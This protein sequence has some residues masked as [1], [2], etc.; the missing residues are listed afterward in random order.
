MDLKNRLQDD[1]KTAMRGGDKDR[2]LTLRMLSAAIKQREIDERIVLDDAQVLAVVEKLIK[3]RREAAIQY[4]AGNRP[5]LAAK[6]LGEAALLQGYL[7][8]RCPKLSSTR[9]SRRRSPI[10][11]GPA[12]GH[13]PDH[14]CAQAEDSGPGRHGRSQQ[15]PQEPPGRLTL[16]FM[17]RLD[18]RGKTGMSGS[19]PQEFIDEVL[20]RSDLV[21]LVERRI[22]SERPAGIS[23]L[24]AR[25]TTKDP[26]FTV[27][28]DKQFYHCF[29]CGA[30]GNA[31]GFLMAFDRLE[32]RDAVADLAAEAG[33]ALPAGGDAPPARH[34]QLRSALEAV[35]RYFRQ[36]LRG[37]HDAIDYLKSRGLS[38]STAATFGVGYAPARWDGVL[39]QF[40]ATRNNAPCCWS[41][42]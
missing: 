27:S 14:G 21:G 17:L 7:P 28:P 10:T 26:S 36:Q 1:I 29:G 2:L 32:F 30:H 18:G 13:G 25:S 42:G 4:E 31:I 19:I 12:S 15:A 39:T 24:A 22:P 6:E 9:S 20:A 33:L 3:Q 8:S 41:A 35:A 38:G 37:A 5:E 11:A 34:L 40:G 16:R 23:R